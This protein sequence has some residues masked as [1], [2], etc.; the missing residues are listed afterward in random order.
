VDQ[1][2]ESRTRQ[3]MPITTATACV[4]TAGAPHN[5]K[6]PIANSSRPCTDVPPRH[7]CVRPRR[8]NWAE[9]KFVAQLA[10]ERALTHVRGSIRGPDAAVLVDAEFQERASGKGS[11]IIPRGDLLLR[12]THLSAEHRQCVRFA[13]LHGSDISFG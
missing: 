12:V 7:G 4:H 3:T 13:F 2:R 8:S 11:S 10:A 1:T 9:I 6:Q 5:S